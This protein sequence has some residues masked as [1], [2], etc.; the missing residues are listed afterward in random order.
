MPS[1]PERYRAQAQPA[2][3]LQETEDLPAL[4]AREEARKRRSTLL[5]M[6]GLMVV[7][8][9]ADHPLSVWSV[10]ARLGMAAFC[11]VVGWWWTP[12][13]NRFGELWVCRAS[14]G[15][16]LV[17]YA[18]L[19]LAT[20]SSESIA[21]W[22]TIAVPLVCVVMLPID[23]AGATVGATLFS[24][25]CVGMLWN[26]GV[27]GED[28][29]AKAVDYLATIGVSAF[30]A[31]QARGLRGAATKAL[32]TLQSLQSRAWEQERLATVGRLAAGVAHEVNNPLAFVKANVRCLAEELE[33]RTLDDAELRDLTEET[34]A[35][36]SR[37]ESIVGDLKA[38]ARDVPVAPG[39]CDVRAVL[40]ECLRM[41]R[42]RLQSVAEVSVSLP[43]DLP[44]ANADAR[45]LVQVLVNLLVNASDAL[46]SARDAGVLRS[47]P[48]VFISVEVEGDAVEV[49]VRDNGPGI[50][51]EHLP[52]L[53]T[54]FFTT[55]PV[56]KGT[57]LGL[58]VSL[59]HLEQM[60][61]SLTAANASDG[62]AVFTAR[63]PLAI[64]TAHQVATT[65]AVGGQA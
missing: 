48:A 37:I 20:G 41:T 42:L 14:V 19:V 21:F 43:P 45:R 2:G 54:P 10:L 35:G 51:A 17:L 12:L 3:P 50:P 52:Q 25:T 59:A 26:D 55:K 30:A 47:E 36:L 29:A 18:L 58:P 40:D 65:R 62:G 44:A 23:T 34:S 39:H 6:A 49:S 16:I 57:G 22:W 56:G 61:G 4:R 38:F 32:E 46:E 60:G 11:A 7:L 13:L 8:S 27:R 24:A 31:Y 53:F 63:V 5:G 64:G 1:A 15:G 9:P 28:F 33:D